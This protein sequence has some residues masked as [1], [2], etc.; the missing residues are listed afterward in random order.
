M[1][2]LVDAFVHRLNDHRPQSEPEQQL[3]FAVHDPSLVSNKKREGNGVAD[4]IGDNSSET[5]AGT[6]D[7]DT[8]QGLGGSDHI[9]G[10]D[11]ADTISGGDGIDE[12]DGGAGNDTIYG[13]SIA[14]LDP[15]SGT[16]Q[17]TLLA[18][19]GARAVFVT[20]A[21]G[22]DGFVYALTKDDGV[23]SRIDTATG[24]STPFLDI[25][26]EEFT[27][28]GEQ[29]V[30]GLAFHPDY[31]TNGRFFVYLTNADG[32]CEIREYTHQPGNP[33]TAD[34]AFVQTIITIPHPTNANHNGGSILF[35]PDGLLYVSVGDGGGFEPSNNAQKL[36]VL[37]G[38]ILRIDIDSDAFPG[39]PTRNYATPPDNPF[40]GATPG[41]DEIWDYGLRNP[42]RIS[43]D[44]LTGDL[45]I[46]DVGHTQ[47]EE[48]DYEEA[49]SGGGFN[50]GWKLREGFI[51]GPGWPPPGPLSLTDPVLDYDH[52]VGK[53]ITGG[54]VYRGPA[55]G[56]EGVYFFADFI[57]GRLFTLRMVDGVAEDAIDR[58]GQVVGANLSYVSSFGTDGAGNLYVV[59]FG[60]EIFRLDPTVAAG[61]G[62]DVLA[63]A[64]GDDEIYGGAGSDLLDGGADDDALS[65]GIGGDTLKG[66]ADDDTLSGD[67]GDDFLDGGAGLDVLDGGGDVDTVDYRGET[68]D[69]TVTLN[70][71]TDA[72]VTV[73]GVDEDTISNIENVFG[74]SG[75]DTLTGDGLAN[76]FRGGAGDD[77][78]DGAGGVDT[79]DF[80][81]K[82]GPVVVTLNG[83]TAA[84]VTIGGSVEDTVRRI[85]NVVGGSYAD[86]LTGDA[87]PNRL[88]GGG[89]NDILR[90]GGGRDTLDGG[91]GID[92]ADYRDKTAAVVVTLS[93]ATTATV[94][95][96]GAL[97]DN[98]RNIENVYGGS[99]ADSLT[100][101]DAANFLSGFTGDD[102]LRGG[103]G[104]DTLDGWG[105]I[106]TADYRDKTAAVVVTLAG[107]TSATVTVGGTAEDTIRYVENVLGGSGADTLTGDGKANLFAGG[108]GNDTLTG[109]AGA[110]T[111]RFDTTLN[112]STNVDNITDFAVVDTIALENAVFTGLA[113]GTL[114]ASAFHIGV[115][116]ADAADRIIY[117]DVTGALYF[118]KDGAGATAAI[119][120]ANLAP[121]LALTNADFVVT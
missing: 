30:L 121:S 107:A 16:I 102:I 74:G 69:V 35:G 72:T 80:S 62:S 86:R 31:D 96:G 60:G 6:S 101:D 113:A 116:A 78:L 92:T 43:F 40:G 110:D 46:G 108:L 63:G 79:A 19:A 65:G 61:D 104:A 118:D 52:T 37:L 112:G 99:A 85:E 66:G 117:N 73:G 9:T 77:T 12:V 88:V 76:F 14:D 111:F 36:D 41:A 67:A 87:V 15:G 83:A 84:T 93:G 95:V 29:G 20:A 42:W 5:I 7:P 53:S 28:G 50:Y 21:P 27:G 100:G 33:P 59:T 119:Q 1:Q 17:A 109:A 11:G 13:H 64:A 44:P 115:S 48:V 51:N 18:D 55:P 2:P 34:A 49:G 82:V 57:T 56:L 94:T 24:A 54:Y 81:D 58:T 4:L 3:D 38:K 25:P 71:G 68:A 32:D 105:G 120:F 70:G 10:L 89:G 26:Q 39:D 114:A 45:Y 75:D 22:D 97:D 90:G 106:D 8:I 23:I 47:R 91:V 98:I 103:L